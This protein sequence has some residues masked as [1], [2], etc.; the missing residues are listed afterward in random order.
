MLS[1]VPEHKTNALEENLNL[2]FEKELSASYAE[3]E[4]VTIV[5]LIKAIKSHG[6]K[7][8][9][10]MATHVLI[11]NPD[12]A[13]N[14]N[15]CLLLEALLEMAGYHERQLLNSMLNYPHLARH[16]NTI[17]EAIELLYYEPLGSY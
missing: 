13:A 12:L 3:A 16:H 10:H 6:N 17:T 7:S 11:S 8:F 9:L 1:T 14:V 2:R 5:F 4:S 15:G